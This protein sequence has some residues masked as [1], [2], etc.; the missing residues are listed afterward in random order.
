MVRKPI[1]RGVFVS[2]VVPKPILATVGFTIRG[3]LIEA[4][5]ILPAGELRSI[6]ERYLSLG[7]IRGK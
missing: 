3:K 5:L 2:P 4:G 1:G 7:L 6:R